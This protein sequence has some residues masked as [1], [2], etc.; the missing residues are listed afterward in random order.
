[1]PNND[2]DFSFTILE[3]FCVLSSGGGW[4]KELNLISWNGNKPK[5]D[6]REWDEQ[7]QRMKKGITLRNE[8]AERLVKEAYGYL[9]RV[10]EAEMRRPVSVAAAVEETVIAAAT[11]DAPA[12]MP[13]DAPV[14]VLE[15]VPEAVPETESH[16]GAEIIAEAGTEDCAEDSAE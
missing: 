2:R 11:A 10:K 14:E 5:L 6:I 7:H 13:A 9:K 3:H 15:A 8:E 1:M 12:N 16:A 4:S